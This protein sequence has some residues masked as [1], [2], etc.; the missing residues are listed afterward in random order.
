VA[1][2]LTRLAWLMG[3]TCVAIGLFHLLLGTASVPGE[4]NAGATVDSRERF[5]GAIF[6]GF[7][8][9]WCWAARQTP[10]PARLVRWL[11][12]IFLLGG[13]GRVLSLV[14]HGRP[15]WFQEILTVIELALPLLF[16]W[17]ASAHDAARR[18]APLNAP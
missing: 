9:A 3:A 15:N 5:Y 17:L 2:A 12:G 1:K 14:L 4:G 13:I 18:T 11:A 8:I 6:A 16:L 10:M 7:G